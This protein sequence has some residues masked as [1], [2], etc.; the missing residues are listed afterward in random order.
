VRLPL[1]AIVA[2]FAGGIAAGLHPQIA[3]HA[4]SLPVIASLFLAALLLILSGLMLARFSRVAGSAAASAL[5]WIAV[6]V[7]A[8]CVANQPRTPEHVVSRIEAGQ[9]SLQTPLRWHGRLRDEPAKL[10]WGLGFDIALTG[11]DYEGRLAALSGGLRL[12]FSPQPGDALPELHAGDSVLAV[13]QAKLPQV[14]RDDGAFDRRAY[15]ANQHTD[16]VGTLRSPQLLER[17][18]EA[19]SWLSTVLPRAR[20]RLR[21]EI[22]QLFAASP[23]VAATMRAML[24]GDRSFVERSEADAFQKT[25][26]FHILVVAGLHVG[27]IAFALFWI[28]RRLRVS[29]TWTA[30]LTLSLLLAYVAVVEQRPPVLRAAIMA[31]AVLLGSVFFRR[32][33]LL[34][35]AALAALVLL[36]AQPLELRDSSFQLSFLAIGCIAGIAAPWLD[37]TAQPYARA[38]HGW[39]D[40][41]RDVSHEPRAAQFR[42]DLR[43][44]AAWASARLPSRFAEPLQNFGVFGVGSCLRIWELLVLTVV[45]QVGMLPLIAHDFHRVALSGP[46]VNLAAV[47]LTG[48]LVPLGF[49]TLTAGLFSSAAGKLLALPVSWITTGLLHIVQWFADFPRWSYRIPGPPWP[50]MTLFFAAAIIFAATFR[51]ETNASRWLRRGLGLVLLGSA[52]LM[53][54]YPFAPQWRAGTLEVTVLDVGQGDSLFVVSPNGRTL[55]IDGGGAFAG[56]RGHEERTSADPGEEAVSPYLWSRGFQKLDVVALTHAHQD[57]LGGLVAILENFR[58]GRLW[59]GREVPSQ[60]LT[61]LEALARHKGIPIEHELRAQKFSWDGVDGE[62]LWPAIRPEEVALSAQNNDSLVLQ[63]RFGNRRI[64]LSGDAEKQAEREILAENPAEALRADVLKIGHHGSKNSSMPDFLAAVRP[65]IAIISVGADNPYGHPNPEALQRLESGGVRVLRTDH[66]GAVH[67]WT[68]G[69]K[70]EVTCFVAC[71]E[72]LSA[73][74]GQLHLPPADKKGQ[75]EQ[76]P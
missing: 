73:A 23:G 14:F 61:N 30:L 13:A 49:G 28:G 68:D 19:S 5:S 32:L 43:S 75:Q 59:I 60:A 1:A 26:V 37:R 58:V 44:A 56:F 20:R 69:Q 57:H 64:L 41:T 50:L 45:L 4:S 3:R 70:L 35:S 2:C 22:D 40:V 24:L 46:I 21:D 36:V 54:V 72:S 53:A 47:P 55:L 34:N 10:P 7:L 39:R 52:F 33:E 63:L 12:N 65:R 8:A 51:I 25:G 9:I 42:I 62:F 48:I 38:L 76:E 15:L 16:L 17:A 18:A 27:A 29:V 66:D 11:V 67:V 31:A 6:G 71:P 74:E